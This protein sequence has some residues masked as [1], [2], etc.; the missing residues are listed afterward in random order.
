MLNGDAA[1]AA[2]SFGMFGEVSSP[3]SLSATSNPVMYGWQGLR[4]D[5]ESGL[6]DNRARTYNASLGRFNSQEPL[7]RD[8]PNMYWSRRNNPQRFSGASGLEASPEFEGSGCSCDPEEMEKMASSHRGEKGWGRYGTRGGIK[9]FGDFKCNLFVNQTTREAG[10]K[11]PL[12]NGRQA[13]AGELADP[14]VNIEGWEVVTD[15]PRS[16]DIVSEAHSGP[17]YSGHTGIVTGGETTSAYT[18]PDERYR[19][20]IHHNDFGF[21]SGPN[22][23]RRR[24]VCR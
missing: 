20:T 1:G 23:V 22:Y 8:G 7:G 15:A 10:V 9:W 24:C 17:G 18:G 11:P 16:G 4:Y 12:V 19:G 3:P 5:A 2:H 14:S 21:R 13:T 6:W